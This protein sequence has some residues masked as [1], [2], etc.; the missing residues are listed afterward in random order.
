MLPDIIHYEL[1][2]KLTS[3]QGQQNGDREHESITSHRQPY[4]TRPSMPCRFYVLPL[5]AFVL[6]LVQPSSASRREF[7]NIARP[8]NPL[9]KRVH[10]LFS[11]SIK[12]GLSTDHPPQPQHPTVDVPSRIR[13]PS[14]TRV[15]PSRMHVPPRTPSSPL[16]VRRLSTLLVNSCS[17]CIVYSLVNSSVCINQKMMARP[18][19]VMDGE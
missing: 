1:Q 18:T 7:R 5:S 19:I 9:L 15:C 4:S 17:V 13:F 11:V 2:A 6:P 16:H 14:H 3:V 12:N 10:L 8:Y